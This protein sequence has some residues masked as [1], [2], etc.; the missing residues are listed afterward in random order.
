MLAHMAQATTIS[1]S[2]PR[3]GFG[4]NAGE[5]GLKTGKLNF[6]STVFPVRPQ[7]LQASEAATWP[8]Q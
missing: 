5:F 8:N 6:E 7:T 4:V 3:S 2:V 1:F